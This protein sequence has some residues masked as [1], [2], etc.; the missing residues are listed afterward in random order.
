MYIKKMSIS[1]QKIQLHQ[2]GRPEMEST[3]TQSTNLCPLLIILQSGL[4]KTTIKE[5]TR[6]RSGKQ[7]YA[8]KIVIKMALKISELKRYT[9]RQQ[10]KVNE[11]VD[12]VN[13]TTSV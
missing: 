6:K 4:Q 2:Q 12:Q 10:S 7:C 8:T 9:D 1:H 13:D 5:P 3:A 11:L